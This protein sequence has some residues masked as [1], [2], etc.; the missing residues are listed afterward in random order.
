[1]KNRFPALLLA[2]LLVGTSFVQAEDTQVL[3]QTRFDFADPKG[4]LK[5]L[6]AREV[7][8]AT[9]PLRMPTS[10]RATEPSS[11]TAGK[12]AIGE[13]APPFALLETQTLPNKPDQVGKLDLD[14]DLRNLRLTRG[15][16][17][18]TCKVTPL[19][20]NAAGL[21]IRFTSAMDD[22]SVIWPQKPPLMVSFG[23]DAITAGIG[24]EPR[25]YTPNV[26]VL[27][28]IEVDLDAEIWSASADG[29]PLIAAAPLNLFTPEGGL[30]LAGALI[31]GLDKPGSRVALSAL[32]VERL[33]SDTPP[34]ET[35][36]AADKLPRIACVG[37]SITQGYGFGNAQVE[38]YPGQLRQLLKGRARVG[39]FG[40][41]GTTML[42]NGDSPYWRQQ[43]FERAKAFA[44]NIVVLMLGTN[45]SK[46]QNF[47]KSDQLSADASALVTAFR[48]LPTHPEVIVV[49]PVP[50]FKTAFGITEEFTA[51]VRPL[52]ELGAKEAGATV[53]N[54][55][56]VFAGQAKW[57]GDGVHPNQK[58]AAAL[59]QFV[60]EQLPLPK[61]NPPEK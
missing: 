38:A 14:W 60:A 55:E 9:L 4:Q 19:D 23:E 27:I 50:V 48:E 58:G 47:A 61:E 32:K 26:P 40:V 54:P 30:M 8:D 18:L 5:Q 22:S 33:P 24:S 25:P 36:A 13:L 12:T 11:I 15:R 51:Q 59:A 10:V 16:Y 39:N 3:I 41:S 21:N 52:V 31:R 7:T 34:S 6:S 20:G 17:A 45:D 29:T 2:T 53:V 43:A 35:R 37:D 57:F 28:Q 49:L 42:K 46:P 44:P 1:M 56:A